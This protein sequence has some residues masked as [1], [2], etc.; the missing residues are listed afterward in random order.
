[1]KRVIVIG[2]GIGGLAAAGRMQN[3]ASPVGPCAKGPAGGGRA[4]APEGGLRPPQRGG[5]GSRFFTERKER[6]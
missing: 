3:G 4:P 5:K 2:A 6:R 1:M